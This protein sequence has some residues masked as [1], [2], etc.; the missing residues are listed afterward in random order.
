MARIR[1][2]ISGSTTPVQDSGYAWPLPGW[3]EWSV[4]LR[5]PP[6]CDNKTHDHSL[7]DMRSGRFGY[8]HPL[9]VTTKLM[10]TPWLIWV[11]SLFTATLAVTT[12]LMTTPWLI[13]VVGLVT[14]TPWLWQQD[15]WPSLTDMSGRFG[16]GHPLP[17]KTRPSFEGRARQFFFGQN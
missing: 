3:Y 6:G 11:V 12:N 1:L 8:G 10:T 4:W 16:Y 15:S 5:P 7:A 9:A 13:W 14:A 2:I 17:V